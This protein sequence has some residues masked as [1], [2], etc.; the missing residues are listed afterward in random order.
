M[1]MFSL[2]HCY[3]LNEIFP[4]VKFFT[5]FSIFI[6]VRLPKGFQCEWYFAFETDSPIFVCSCF[7]SEL[8]ASVSIL[9]VDYVWY[10]KTCFNGLGYCRTA[11]YS[12]LMVMLDKVTEILMK[13][14][15]VK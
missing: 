13:I 14:S 3:G 2:Q 8:E 15:I 9:N 10:C 7:M 4:S 6:C 1:V 5:Y 11:G 12:L